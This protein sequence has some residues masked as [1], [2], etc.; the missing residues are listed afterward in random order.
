M[1]F[2]LCSFLIPSI[3]MFLVGC[4]CPGL[5]TD[6]SGNKVPLSEFDICPDVEL[7]E[8]EYVFGDGISRIYFDDDPDSA[9]QYC[10][11]SNTIIDVVFLGQDSS[12]HELGIWVP[13]GTET[14]YFVTSG[15]AEAYD[16][17]QWNDRLINGYGTVSAT[18]DTV[19]DGN[20]AITIEFYEDGSLGGI[21]TATGTGVYSYGSF[22]IESM[23][24]DPTGYNLDA[25]N[26]GE[27]NFDET[28]EDYPM[29]FDYYTLS[30]EGLAG[31]I[32]AYDE[33]YQN[34]YSEDFVACTD[35]SEDTGDAGDTGDT[36]E[37][38]ED[39]TKNAYRRIMPEIPDDWAYSGI[40][41]SAAL[42]AASFLWSNPVENDE[43]DT[44][45]S[46]LQIWRM[47]TH[48]AW[49]AFFASP[50]GG[51]SIYSLTDVDDLVKEY[52]KEGW[53]M[54][55][56]QTEGHRYIEWLVVDDTYRHVAGQMVDDW[57]QD[58]ITDD[59]LVWYWSLALL[60]APP[61]PPQP[62]G[63]NPPARSPSGQ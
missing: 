8:N 14:E 11:L 57:N 62:V 36:A 22:S 21:L 46:D 2:R 9:S 16:T 50:I 38:G 53:T 39:A 1:S 59:E 10:S 41:P 3:A 60:H 17:V 29:D 37:E 18:L 47:S 26:C 58:Q 55:R 34:T 63:D 6:C 25:L 15:S 28:T 45:P 35:E 54:Q 32:E 49:D 44:S 61:P 12:G 33:L 48:G 56:L 13:V 52:E 19:I 20:Q 5:Y 7:G 42:Y 31:S 51:V 43:G 23:S 30:A 24:G 27:F 40:V 4:N